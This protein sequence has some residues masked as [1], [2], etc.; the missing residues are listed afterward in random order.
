MPPEMATDEDADQ[1]RAPTMAKTT[2][3]SCQ[4]SS[5]KNSAKTTVGAN[6]TRIGPRARDRTY[7]TLT[8]AVAPV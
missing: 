6:A 7:G 8:R 3:P 4:V 5:E 2:S 1:G